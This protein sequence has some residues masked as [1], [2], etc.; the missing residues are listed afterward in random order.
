[1]RARAHKPRHRVLCLRR[2]LKTAKL[3]HPGRD[4][5]V[6]SRV[7]RKLGAVGE[8]HLEPDGHASLDG[9]LQL[10]R[11]F[12]PIFPPQ[13]AQHQLENRADHNPPLGGAHAVSLPFRPRIAAV[14]PQRHRPP[15]ALLRE[16]GGVVP[17]K[18]VE[19]PVYRRD[20]RVVVR[21]P[22]LDTSGRCVRAL[23]PPPSP[24]APPR[25]H[26]R[27]SRLSSR[28]STSAPSRQTPAETGSGQLRHPGRACVERRPRAARFRT[29]PA[30]RAA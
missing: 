8:R 4:L 7:P 1:M 2:L 11:L 19:Y 18:P 16:P 22:R 30:A 25:S 17:P 28:A 23:A 12:A 5:L 6:A 3:E 20:V 15:V 27:S 13:V 24:R 9:C 26:R 21:A 14:T 10:G 29:A